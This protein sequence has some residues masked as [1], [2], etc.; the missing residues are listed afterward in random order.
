MAD[1]VV[2]NPD[3]DYTITRDDILSACGWSPYEGMRLHYRVEQTW[4]NG[5]LA[6]VDGRFTNAQTPLAV[7]FDV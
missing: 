1:I 3:A 2:V 5:Q 7:R 6:Y 4:V